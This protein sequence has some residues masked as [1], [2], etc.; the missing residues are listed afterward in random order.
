MTS[1]GG[2]RSEHSCLVIGKFSSFVL[3]SA[4]SSAFSAPCLSFVC[5]CACELES[6]WGF[7][8]ILLS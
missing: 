6:E 4:G 3:S 8:P 7:K 5:V 2:R 1:A